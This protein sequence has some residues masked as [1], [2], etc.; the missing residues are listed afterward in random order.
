MT[1][2]G[3]FP[4]FSDF[5]LLAIGVP[6]NMKLAINQNSKFYDMGAC[7]PDRT[8]LKGRNEFCGLFRTPSLRNVATRKVFFP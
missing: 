5:G 2:E 4:N 7:G 8:D 1:P 6:R 3:I